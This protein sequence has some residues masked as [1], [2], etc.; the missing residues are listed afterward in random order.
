MALG[1]A[2]M[3]GARRPDRK[4]VFFFGPEVPADDPRV[5]AG[6]P[7]LGPN[8][9]PP[10]M[11][12]LRGA[13]WAYAE[14]TLGVGRRILGAV[15]ASLGLSPDF[16]DSRYR[17]PL[18]RGQ[19]LLYPPVAADAPDDEF[20]VSPH[21]DFGCLTLVLQDASGGLEVRGE[22]GA[23][24]PVPPREGTLVVNVG[25]LLARWSN[26]RLPSTVHRVRHRSAQRRHSVAIFCDPDPEAVIDPRD[27]RLP[28]ALA[29]RY[30]PVTV[31]GYILE[32]NRGV[33][34]HYARA[35]DR[36]EP[37]GVAPPSG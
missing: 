2:T 3:Y 11:P 17:A 20:G 28:A 5:R 27:M 23:W 25:D 13:V 37:D 10:A 6:I 36:L 14:A 4:E 32:R 15:A 31:A 8:R 35:G 12:E 18:G 19:L 22:N 24:I 21:T 26:D 7:L 1:Q 16:F 33:F 9:W 29:P 34:S 30:D